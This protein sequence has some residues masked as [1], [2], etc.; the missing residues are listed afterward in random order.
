MLGQYQIQIPELPALS[1]FNYERIFRLYKTEN[2]QYYY[3][4]LQ[5]ITMPNEVDETKIY[6]MTVRQRQPWVMISFKA[7]QT[8][9]LWW[10]ICLINKIDNPLTM[11]QSGT[12]LKILKPEFIP[13]VLKEID[14]SLK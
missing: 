12:V 11:P 6:Y 13:Q 8:I 4:L 3:N 14:E 2:N 9:E 5:S 1:R 10:L 7:Y